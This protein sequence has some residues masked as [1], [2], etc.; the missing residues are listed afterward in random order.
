MSRCGLGRSLRNC[1]GQQPTGVDCTRISDGREL[2]S[3]RNG[4]VTLPLRYR[5]VTH[6]ARLGKFVLCDLWIGPLTGIADSAPNGHGPQYMP[7]HVY[8]SSA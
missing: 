7:N 4:L 1:S 2:V 8:E 6:A 3:T 5:E